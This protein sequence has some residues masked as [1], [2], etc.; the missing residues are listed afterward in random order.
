MVQSNGLPNRG[1]G[2]TVRCMKRKALIFVLLAGSL[3]GFTA[4]GFAAPLQVFVSILPQKWLVDQVGGELVST[5]VLVDKGQEP[6]NFEPTPRQI[7][8]L[9]RSTIYFTVDMP[10]ERELIRRIQQSGTHVRLIDVTASLEKIPITGQVHGQAS[11]KKGSRKH[12]AG[13]DPHVW[14]APENL[15]IM[16]K[17]MAAA[18]AAADSKN[19]SAYKANLQTVF[20]VLDLLNAQNKKL[21]GPYRGATFFVFHPAFGY[22]AHA[23]GLHQ[24]AVEVAGKLPTPKQLRALIQKAR[25]DKVKVV[26]VQPQFDPKSAQAVARAIGGEVVPLDPLAEDVIGNLTIMARKIQSALQRR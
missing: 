4:A 9:F 26:F 17:T 20:A 12:A 15:K 6:H 5:H 2:T 22:F 23:Y 19:A 13:L 1:W 25:A 24:E 11:S 3:F 7:A 21:L 10:F 8:N 16:A 18:L 14:L